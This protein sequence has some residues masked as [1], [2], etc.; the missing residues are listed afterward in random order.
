MTSG[1]GGDPRLEYRAVVKLLYEMGWH[2]ADKLLQMACTVEAES[3]CYPHAW[4]WNSPAEGGNGSTDWGLFQLND[5]NTGGKPPQL[6]SNGDPIAETQFQVYALDPVRA[7][8]K[9][10]DLYDARGFQPWYGYSKWRNYAPTM[11]RALA[12]WLREKYGIQLL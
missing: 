6:A 9:A 2:D 4:H 1:L 12:N 8:I 3:G 11:T 10:R 5:G 7:A